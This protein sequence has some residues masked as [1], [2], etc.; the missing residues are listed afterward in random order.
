MVEYNGF[1]FCGIKLKFSKEV[2]DRLS[3]KQNVTY[4]YSLPFKNSNYIALK[5]KSKFKLFFFSHFLDSSKN[6]NISVN[7]IYIWKEAGWGEGEGRKKAENILLNL[8]QS[9][10]F[11]KHSNLLHIKTSPT[12]I[13]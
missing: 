12:D 13:N 4:Q 10:F 9:K 2:S 5:F 11:N 8:K 3:F 7:Y 1:N 6:R